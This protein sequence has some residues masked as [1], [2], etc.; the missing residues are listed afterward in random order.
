MS[1]QNILYTLMGFGQTALELCSSLVTN[2]FTWSIDLNGTTIN[3]M[4]IIL[5]GFFIYAAV[6]LAIWIVSLSPL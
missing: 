1:F 5:G 2:F 6:Q 4:N 3:F